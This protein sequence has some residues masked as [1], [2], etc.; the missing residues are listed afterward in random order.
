MDER[1]YGQGYGYEL[2]S[3]HVQEG[4]KRRSQ[5]SSLTKGVFQ[6]GA[7]RDCHVFEADPTFYALVAS[8]PIVVDGARVQERHWQLPLRSFDVPFSL[9]LG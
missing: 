1:R 6:G 3:K 2:S 9:F 4:R 8:Y 5:R 7:G